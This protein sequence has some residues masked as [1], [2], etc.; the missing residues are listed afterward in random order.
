MIV[1]R[2]CGRDFSPANYGANHWHR[3]ARYFY[4]STVPKE[5]REIFKNYCPGCSRSFARHA[6]RHTK[7]RFTELWFPT[8]DEFR[9]LEVNWL[10]HALGRNID[11]TQQGKPLDRCQHGYCENFAST[12]YEGAKICLSCKH[13]LARYGD[14]LEQPKVIDEH[15]V[16]KFLATLE[17]QPVDIRRKRV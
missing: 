13:S 9:Q 8:I 11:R 6:S 14:K 10:I 2:T 15:W 5:H 16:Q 17:Q 12:V 3:M 4:N 1:C 7:R